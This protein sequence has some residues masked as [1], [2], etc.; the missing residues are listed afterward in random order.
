M[1]KTLTGRFHSPRP[2]SRRW[3][4][5]VEHLEERYCLDGSSGSTFFPPPGGPVITSFTVHMLTRKSVELDGTVTDLHPGSVTVSFGGVMTGT[6]STNADGSFSFTA[7]A[8][9]LGTVTAVATDDRSLTSA[10][11][12]G[13]VVSNPPQIDAFYGGVQSGNTWTFQGHVTD[14]SPAGLTVTFSSNVPQ[15]QGQSATVDA[16]G[17][18]YITEVLP[19]G[20]T[21][22]IAAQTWD[23]WSL[24]S[25][26]ARYA[27]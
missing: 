14:E 18:F 2:A 20:T 6:V 10:P 1:L 17:N 3:R 5:Q 7:D 25:N 19:L 26:L 23:W 13:Q 24:Q 16:S 12:G 9:S 4:P 27:F 15:L 21:G 8:S 11:A 22:T